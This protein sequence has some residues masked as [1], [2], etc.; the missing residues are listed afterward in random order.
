MAKKTV[1]V[2]TKR[3]NK[4]RGVKKYT[5]SMA[6]VAVFLLSIP[7]TVYIAQRNNNS[8]INNN[9]DKQVLQAASA[10][11]SIVD[12]EFSPATITIPLGTTI[13]WTNMSVSDSDHTTSSDVE[14]TANS[15]D[16]GLTNPVASSGL[17]D[18]FSHTFTATGTFTYHCNV[19]T[20]MHGTVIVTA[21][22]ATAPTA[23]TAPAATATTAP[24]PTAITPTLVCE[25][26]N[27][28]PPCATIP[29]TESTAPAPTSTT[30]APTIAPVTTASPTGD[31]GTSNPIALIILLI[32]LILKFLK[33]LL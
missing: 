10:A 28:T 32:E 27:G 17:P 18:T 21:A 25:G 31:G 5:L 19:H 1:K 8:T 9:N 22:T 15:W 3:Q 7:F 23:T 12:F 26:G 29:P 14:G 20:F 24:A 16:S 11:V 2:K 33:S 13:T 30:A 4:P 6:I